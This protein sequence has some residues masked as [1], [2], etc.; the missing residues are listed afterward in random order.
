MIAKQ[1]KC[2]IHYTIKWNVWSGSHILAS[3]EVVLKQQM[4]Q[5][6]QT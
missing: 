2:F 3:E 4:Q 6:K 1:G 5:S